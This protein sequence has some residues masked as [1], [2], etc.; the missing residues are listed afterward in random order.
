MKNKLN[1]LSPQEHYEKIEYAHQ[2]IKSDVIRELSIA[3]YINSNICG[4][5]GKEQNYWREIKEVFYKKHN[6]YKNI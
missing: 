3:D 6:N 2:T 4:C 1:K 5:R